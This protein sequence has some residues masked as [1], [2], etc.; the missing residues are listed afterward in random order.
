MISYV[1]YIYIYITWYQ[2]ECINCENI[3]NKILINICIIFSN[4]SYQMIH[5]YI[6]RK[7]CLDGVHPIWS[8]RFEL[9]IT[10]KKHQ[11]LQRSKNKLI[12]SRFTFEK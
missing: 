10:Q 6:D 7:G 1:S 5:K 8:C 12:Y 11:L 4:V 3:S 2:R 9:L